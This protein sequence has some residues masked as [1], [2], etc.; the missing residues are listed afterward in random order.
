MKRCWIGAA[1][2]ALMLAGSV[3]VSWAMPRLHQPVARQL[4]QAAAFAQQ[5]R[6]DQAQHA[7]S[8]ARRDWGKGRALRGLVSDHTPGEAI[9][10]A[11]AELTAWSQ[12]RDQDAFAAA[13]A[14]TA[15]LVEAMADSHSLS[16]FNFL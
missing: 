10:S 1:L 15:A 9:D 4:E 14:R 16:W 12:G 6:M 7:V 2:L 11:L 13:C 8:Q 3:A 5:G